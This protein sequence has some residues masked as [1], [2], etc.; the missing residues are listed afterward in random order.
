MFQREVLAL[1]ESQARAALRLGSGHQIIK[2]PTGTG[3]TLVL[4][5]RCCHLL[6][7]KNGRFM[8]REGKEIT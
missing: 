1:D 7:C 3:K 4:V 6:C 5:H 2:G 8:V